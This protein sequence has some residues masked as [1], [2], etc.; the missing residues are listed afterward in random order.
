MKPINKLIFL[1]TAA[2]FLWF[3]V[4]AC[5]TGLS[6]APKFTAIDSNGDPWVGAQL[7]TYETGT[8]TPKTTWTDATKVT[9][10]TNPVVLDSYGQADVWLDSSGGAYRLK[11]LDPDGP[12]V[13]T[14]DGVHDA[15]SSF[16]AGMGIM[17]NP[18]K[19]DKFVVKDVTAG[20]MKSLDLE[21]LLGNVYYPNPSAADQGATGNS[22]TIKY[23]VDTIGSDQA[24]IVLRHNSGA[25]TTTYTLATDE[26]IPPNIT[27]KFEHGA[28]IDGVA[29]GGVETLAI[30]GPFDPGLY[31]VLG[32]NLSVSFGSGSVVGVLPE[33]WGA[34]ADNLDASATLNGTALTAASSACSSGHGSPGYDL[35]LVLASGVYKVTSSAGNYAVII[36]SNM[37][38]QSAQGSVIRQ[39]GLGH[40]LL[41]DGQNNAAE[42]MEFKSFSVYGNVAG[43]G[44]GITTALN[45]V[46][47]TTYARFIGVKSHNNGGNGLTHVAAWGTSYIDCKFNDNLGLG[48]YVSGV[49]SN[50]IN[51]LM[52]EARR[53]G[54]IV[55][56][57]SADYT[58]GGILIQ[59]ANLVNWIGGIIE[60]NSAWNVLIGDPDN[61]VRPLGVNISHA[62]LE[63]A[64]RATS[65][66][67]TGGLI[68]AFNKWDSL[69]VTNCILSYGAPS[70]RIGYGLYIVGDANNEQ[71]Q[72]HEFNNHY[73]IGNPAGTAYKRNISGIYSGKEQVQDRISTIAILNAIDAAHIKVTMTSNWN[74]DAHAEQDNI[75]KDSV[76]TGVWKLSA[77]GAALTLDTTGITNNVKAITTAN[78]MTNESGT[79]LTILPQV[80]GTTIVLSFYNAAAAGSAV[81]LTTLVDTGA[82]YVWLSYKTDFYEL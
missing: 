49:N 74:G 1:I 22:D 62:F 18:I 57:N 38:G 10:N 11:L 65:A 5:S 41:L 7:F 61:S 37:R 19:T 42:G 59:G 67:V 16:T 8:V 58:K 47:T 31:Q 55:D 4:P 23:A 15:A 56:D 50:G 13:W 51:F 82:I 14:V 77:S 71:T 54:G 48:V 66:S 72:F 29:G 43:S 34:K 80:S 53:N 28:V 73:V 79:A 78:I 68:K 64:P 32:S 52:C 44:T 70:G 76:L 6:P 46:T 20:T 63:N 3:T 75:G 30:N 17:T 81:D 9:P 69:S 39:I 24:T 21:D 45:G 35:E 33:W 60:G 40:T 12:T 2:A 25:A 26:T 27:L 36:N